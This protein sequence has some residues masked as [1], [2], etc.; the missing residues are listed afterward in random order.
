MNNPTTSENTRGAA[1]TPFADDPLG[2][3]AHPAPW[4]FAPCIGT[5]QGLIN[6][7]LVSVPVILLKSMGVSNTVIGWASFATLPMAVK[8]LFGPVIDANKTKRWWILRSGEW[9]MASLVLLALS[10]MQSS[11]SLWLYLSALTVLAVA[12]S[13]QQI[14]LQGFFTLSLTKTE[15]A[16]FSGLDP[17]FGRVATVVSGSVLIALAGIAG[18]RYGDPRITWG[19]Y[20]GILIIIFGLLYIYTR[21]TFPRPVADHAHRDASGKAAALPFTD[22]LKNYFSLPHLWAGIVYIFFLRSGET[23]IAK[24]GPAFLMDKPEAGGL[25]LSIPE[26]GAL[27]GVMSIC[28]MAGGTLSGV[29]LRSR[30]LRRVVWPFTLAAI[31]PSAVYVYLSLHSTAHHAITVDFSCIGIDRVWQFDWVLA[32]LLGVEN[33]G[34]GLG[35]TVMNFFMFRM[36]AGSKYPASIVALNASV[37]YLSYL[38]FGAIS[39]VIQETVGYAWLFVLSILVSLPAF[40]AIPFLNYKLDER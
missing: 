17:V 11:F 40:A 19:S 21:K 24:M 14:A 34:F 20:F 29:C 23:F 31:F 3:G 22:V 25:D 10:L 16:L 26:V 4:R 8:F 38:V 18:E 6:P 15:Q 35:F 28:A 30:G 1:P 5:W 37:I 33:F 39:G 13:F 12:K 2:R 27:T 32:L 36:A 7:V 9:L